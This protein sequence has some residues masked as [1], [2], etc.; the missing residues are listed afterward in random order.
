M[1]AEKVEECILHDG[2]LLISSTLINSCV[3]SSLELGN[4]MAV[5][6]SRAAALGPRS[7]GLSVLRLRNSDDLQA[8]C[9]PQRIV[10]QNHPRD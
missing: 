4:D 2:A 10:V 7:H 5:N 1:Q 8:T 9:T 3:C 6:E